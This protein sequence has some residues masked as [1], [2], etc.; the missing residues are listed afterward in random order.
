MQQLL[1]IGCLDIRS[2]LQQQIAGVRVAVGASVMKGSV[3]KTAMCERGEGG[4]S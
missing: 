1:E 4:L 3:V 2:T